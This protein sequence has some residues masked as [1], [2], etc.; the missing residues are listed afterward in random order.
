[1]DGDELELAARMYE[2]EHRWSEAAQLWEARE[3]WLKAGRAWERAGQHKK[4]L[5]ALAR[6][7]CFQDYRRVARSLRIAGNDD[8]EIHRLHRDVLRQLAQED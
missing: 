2:L 4:S 3:K 8:E 5:K 6:G 1:M 7:H